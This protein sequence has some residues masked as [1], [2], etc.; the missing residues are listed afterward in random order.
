[1]PDGSIT[2]NDTAIRAR[3][4]Q[5]MDEGARTGSHGRNAKEVMA[6][7][8]EVLAVGIA[9]HRTTGDIGPGR[10][11][12]MPAAG[13]IGQV[14]GAPGEDEATIAGRTLAIYGRHD[15]EALEDIP[16][17]DLTTEQVLILA[18]QEIIHWL[19]NGDL[20]VRQLLDGVL[21][22]ADDEAN[23]PRSGRA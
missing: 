17:D 3:A 12:A 13:R 2:A 11:S 14:G 10:G 16:G 20:T 1:M 19:G 18:Y 15:G 8:S 7:L 6:V 21:A 4:C 23:Q 9:R 22:D 5:K